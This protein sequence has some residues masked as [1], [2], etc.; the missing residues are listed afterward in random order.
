MKCPKICPYEKTAKYTQGSLSRCKKGWVDTCK[1]RLM[2]N[3]LERAYK[4]QR[5]KHGELVYQWKKEKGENNMIM[6]KK[7]RVKIIK[8]IDGDVYCAK[9]EVFLGSICDPFRRTHCEKCFSR[10]KGE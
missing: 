10:F 7:K 9:C 8:V 4:K 5:V 2:L 3:R 6:N 1:I